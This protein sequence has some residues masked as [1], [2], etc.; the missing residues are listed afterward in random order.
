MDSLRTRLPSCANDIISWCISRR[1][2]LNASKTEAE[3]IWV[4]L[5]SSLAK[6]SNRDYYIQIGISTIKPSFKLCCLIHSAVLG[7]ASTI[8][9]T[10]LVPSTAVVHVA[11]FDLH[12]R[13]TS[14]CY[15]YAPS[16][17]SVSSHMPARLHGTHCRRKTQILAGAVTDPGLFRKQFKT[18]FLVWRSVFADSLGDSNAV[19]MGCLL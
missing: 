5:R 10:S 3:A 15:G 17:A 19:S 2:Q 13:R 7:S 16:S 9:P 8:L 14:L 1:L 18:H 12:C 4:R 6:L 11:V